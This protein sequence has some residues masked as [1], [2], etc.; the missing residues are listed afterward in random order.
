MIACIHLA[1][2]EP[3]RPLRA[4]PA[5]ARLRALPAEA[6]L[7]ALPTSPP[8][9]ALPARPYELPLSAASRRALARM[10]AAR[11]SAHPRELLLALLRPG[12]EATLAAQAIGIEPAS[13]AGLFDD[14]AATSRN[15]SWLTAQRRRFVDVVLEIAEAEAARAG[16][17]AVS[18]GYLL[19][20]LLACVS[21]AVWPVTALTPERFRSFRTALTAAR[22]RTTE[23]LHLTTRARALADELDRAEARRRM[24]RLERRA[25]FATLAAVSGLGTA[26]AALLVA[27]Y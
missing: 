1:R 6:P 20:G 24:Q 16:E 26:M 23:P 25:R 7:R 14:E 19:F 15:L 10:S 8:A 27:L 21:A 5:S 18:E 3:P 12:G 17:T 13:L 11:P 9:R 4:L 22:R 2:P